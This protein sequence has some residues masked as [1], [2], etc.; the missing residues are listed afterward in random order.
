MTRQTAFGDFAYQSRRRASKRR[1]G[2]RIPAAFMRRIDLA[3]RHCAA[4]TQTGMFFSSKAL[5]DR[6]PHPMR[7]EL[8]KVLSG[9]LCRRTGYDKIF[10]AVMSVADGEVPDDPED[11][12]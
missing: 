2:S 1:A 4:F 10:K 11:G 5:P 7:D 3:A 12:V 6:N 9:N 8:K